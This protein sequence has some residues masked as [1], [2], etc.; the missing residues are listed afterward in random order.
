M[1]SHFRLS[2]TFVL[3]LLSGIMISG[4]ASTN[5]QSKSLDERLKQYEQ[6]IRW[7]QW[8]GAVEYLAPEYLQNNRLSRL[9]M[10]RFRLFKVTH[11]QVRSAAATD[12]GMGYRQTVEIRM[13]NRTRAVERTLIDQQEWRYNTVHERWYLHSGL[14]DVTRAR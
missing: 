10:D 5:K 12:A 8:E 14:P 1:K 13:F 4:C 11:Y 7:S 3:I 9:D 2:L 6:V